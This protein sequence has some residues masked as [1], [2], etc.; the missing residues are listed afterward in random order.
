V[1]RNHVA[2]DKFPLTRWHI[3]PGGQHMSEVT[4]GTWYRAS[5][6][7]SDLGLLTVADAFLP[8]I[9]RGPPT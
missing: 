6:T 3:L 4:Q 9:E 2:Q 1:W 8:G 5:V 7:R